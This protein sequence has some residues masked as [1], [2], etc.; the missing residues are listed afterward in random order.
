MPRILPIGIDLGTTFSVIAYVDESG[1]SVVLRN[2]EGEILTPSVVLFS[3]AE[4]VVGRHARTALFINPDL[5][6]E[7]VKRDMGAPY[8]SRPIHGQ[9]L[10]PEVIQACILRKLKADIVQR[11]TADPHVVITVPAYFDEPRRKATA[12]AGEMAGLKVLD[13]VNEPTAAALAFGEKLGYLTPGGTPREEMNVLVYDLGGGTFDVTLLH[14]APGRVDTIA[15]D[16]DVQLGG[17]DWDLRLV[18]YLCEQFRKAHRLDP[19]QDPIAANRVLAA[20]I[21]AKHAL[22]ARNRTTVQIEY[23]GLTEE[24]PVW[25]ELFNELT[26]DLLERTAYTTRQLIADA[27]MEW[28]D[29]SR[30]LLVGGSTR[31]P[32]VVDMLRKMT[33]I[34]PDRTVNP[35][36]AVARGAALYAA[37]LLARRGEPGV[38]AHFEVTNV[39]SHSLGIEGIDPETMRKTNVIL[40]PRNT[41]LPAKFTERFMT[42][43]EN[44]RSIVIQVLEGES[45][46]PSE[47]T[48]IGRTVIR[49]LP[50]GL[51]K[52]WP[53][54]VTFEY[55]TNG[56]LSVRA[57]VP[58]TH[59]K[60]TL[61]LERTAGLSTTGIAGWRQL[62]E[63][64]AGFAAFR[65]ASQQL[66][67][68]AAAGGQPGASFP[69]TSP[70]TAPAVATTDQS[71]T[72]VALPT[73][74]GAAGAG[75]TAA[76]SFAVHAGIGAPS[77]GAAAAGPGGAA[78]ASSAA[79]TGAAAA[80]GPAGAAV[81]A[82][83][84]SAAPGLGAIPLPLPPA[85]QGSLAA[86][87]P[88]TAGSWTAAGGPPH[89]AGAAAIGPSGLPLPGAAGAQPAVAA[90]ALGAQAVATASGPSLGAR[91]ANAEAARKLTIRLQIPRWLFSA[92]GY[93]VSAV[94]GLALGAVVLWLVRPDALRH[95]LKLFGG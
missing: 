71:A 66:L 61:E 69:P 32:M 64:G 94:L 85:V 52:G 63:S 11:L 60:A 44:Q 13:I 29:V 33:G 19:R 75:T 7:W 62:V 27:K 35:D 15:T 93:V 43:T 9:Y 67:P 8:Y 31:M 18:D 23:G 76:Q 95:L 73:P 91:M 20:A 14:L 37:Y 55:G 1:K 40:I 2:A 38:T 68:A 58:G 42:K 77:A 57:V 78:P 72:T 88:G 79:A 3:D 89:G 65:A 59:H 84:A 5:V 53:V 49:D 51:P 30:V 45:S 21:D 70:A 54:D 17:H 4:V 56:R 92:V 6:A 50:A 12:D 25:R 10:P 83:P 16:G 26:A 34:E 39:N 86:Q 28:K 74:Y 22:T 47:C 80:G 82:G 41:R 90:N 48:A 46:L 36:E 24:I 87:T 81:A